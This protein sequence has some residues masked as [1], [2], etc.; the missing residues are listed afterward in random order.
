MVKNKLHI[1]GCSH[2]TACAIDEKDGWPVKLSKKLKI[3][4]FERIGQTGMG[5]F[6]ILYDMILRISNNQIQKDDIVVLNTSYC[7]RWSSVN[8][9]H[10]DNNKNRFTEFV[11]DLIKFEGTTYPTNEGEF[12]F[13]ENSNT[14]VVFCQWLINTLYMYNTLKQ[15]CDNVSI[16]FLDGIDDLELLTNTIHEVYEVGNSVNI[17]INPMTNQEIDNLKFD[18]SKFNNDIITPPISTSKKQYSNWH[19]WIQENSLIND[20]HMNKFAHHYFTGYLYNFITQKNKKN[21]K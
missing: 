14:T 5:S 21:T 10:I 12:D 8:F 7:T 20:G 11:A 1:F 2:S 17:G 15:Y 9:P 18:I 6:N 4:L 19:E 13:T 16:W 3:E